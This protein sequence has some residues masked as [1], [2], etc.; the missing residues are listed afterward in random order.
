MCGRETASVAK[1]R[2][3]KEAKSLVLRAERC[4]EPLTALV[5]VRGAKDLKSE[6]GFSQAHKSFSGARIRP[7]CIGCIQLLQDSSKVR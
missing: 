2:K 4:S 7:P 3:N 5:P 6:V 1:R